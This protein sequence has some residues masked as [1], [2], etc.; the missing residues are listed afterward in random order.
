MNTDHALF[1]AIDRDQS[2][3]AANEALRNRCE[4]ALIA[5]TPA[6][7][8]ERVATVLDTE[9]LYYLLTGQK[10][11]PQYDYL[12]AMDTDELCRLAGVSE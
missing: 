6:E 4:S 2:D 7:L 1:A 9:T 10:P 8:A 12:G 11:G 3:D 5:M